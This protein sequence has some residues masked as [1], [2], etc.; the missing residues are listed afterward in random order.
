MITL[1]RTMENQMRGMR[2]DEEDES[3]VASSTFEMSQSAD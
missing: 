1:I 2:A 3:D